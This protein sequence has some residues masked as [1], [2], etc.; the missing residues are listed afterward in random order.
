MYFLQE[1][2]VTM[3]IILTA[4]APRLNACTH[5]H[6]VAIDSLCGRTH[7]HSV[8][9]TSSDVANRVTSTVDPLNTR[10]WDCLR[11]LTP[12]WTQN[13]HLQLLAAT[14]LQGWS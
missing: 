2:S 14:F 6:T 4:E 1:K 9:A 11:S 10:V 5:T 3:I 13:H 7:T 8:Q 12:P